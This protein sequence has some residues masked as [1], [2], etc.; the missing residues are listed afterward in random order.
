MTTKFDLWV[1]KVECGKKIK[2]GYIVMHGSPSLFAEAYPDVLDW[3][4]YLWYEFILHVL[5]ILIVLSWL[6]HSIQNFILFPDLKF[7]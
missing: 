1:V 2:L 3:V 4:S 7:L 5:F 6:C